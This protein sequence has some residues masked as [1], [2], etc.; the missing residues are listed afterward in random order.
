MSLATELQQ[1]LAGFQQNAPEPVKAMITA[2]KA[3][4][5]ADFNREA[6]IHEGDKLPGFTLP[7]A[8]SEEVSSSDL[9]KKGPLL[10]TFYRGTWCPFCNL[11]L[12]H[13]QKH[14]TEFEAK[15]VTLVA[16]S[17]ELP[18]TSLSESEKRGLKFPVL[19]DAGNAYARKLGIVWKQP[20][21]LRPVF[22]SFGHNLPKR[23]GDDSLEVPIP[24]T[25]LVDGK[26]VVRNAFIEAD[27]TKRLE[28]AVALEWVNKL[29]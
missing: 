28:P 23:N 16:I 7:N 13:L 20:D 1:V 21:S 24:T 10:I 27:Y 6:A 4:I 14:L 29:D 18:D 2:A 5:E 17:P 19:S 3:Q 22:D 12:V 9:L 25:L 11:A 8:L 26:G 15:G